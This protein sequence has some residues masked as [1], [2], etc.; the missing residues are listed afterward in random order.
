[1]IKG[2]ENFRVER[3]GRYTLAK[4]EI[5]INIPGGGRETPR[6]TVRG[7]VLHVCAAPADGD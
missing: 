2:K 7:A 3:P 4:E 6:T 5:K 1:M